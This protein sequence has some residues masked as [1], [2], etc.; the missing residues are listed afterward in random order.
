M[1]S[2]N[3]LQIVK[4][5]E[6]IVPGERLRTQMLG[7]TATGHGL[8]TNGN[9]G[10][11]LIRLEAGEAFP[12]HTHPGDHLLYVLRGRGTIT[13]DGVTYEVQPGELYM[14]D[15]LAEHSVGAV[16]EHWLMSIGSPHKALDAT[17]RMKI[18]DEVRASWS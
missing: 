14:V 15:G 17:D 1:P 16:D 10:A 12:M 11:D 6:L 4:V 9:L 5:P 13:V 3:A 2:P 7:T 8:V 18:V